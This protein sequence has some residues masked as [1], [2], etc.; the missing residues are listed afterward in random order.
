VNLDL[1]RNKSEKE[2]KY[3]LKFKK[4]FFLFIGSFAGLIARVQA[5]LF[6][7]RCDSS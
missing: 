3:N 7:G 2:K 5:E 1:R 6:D 4:S